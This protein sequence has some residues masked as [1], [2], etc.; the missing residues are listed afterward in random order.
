MLWLHSSNIFPNKPAPKVPNKIQRNLLLCSS[1]SFLT[2]LVTTFI[3]KSGYDSQSKDPLYISLSAAD[4][5]AVNPNVTSA[6]LCECGI[7]DR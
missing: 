1:V 6:Y 3:N 4:S 7:S 5:A 2:V